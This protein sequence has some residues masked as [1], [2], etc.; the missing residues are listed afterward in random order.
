MNN[1]VFEKWW[2]EFQHGSGGVNRPMFT[3]EAYTLF[4]LGQSDPQWKE[5]EWK[6]MTTFHEARVGNF[7]FTAH[8]TG[9]WMMWYLPNGER[10]TGLLIDGGQLDDLTSAQSACVSALK[11]ELEQFVRT[12]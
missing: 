1:E 2:A 4:R 12:V 9:E 6:R 3:A 8:N 11:K 5:P 10:D 7:R